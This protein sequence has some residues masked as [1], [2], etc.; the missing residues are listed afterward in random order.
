MVPPLMA[1]VP[2]LPSGPLVPAAPT[3]LMFSLPE[4]SVTPPVKVLA[5]SK[6]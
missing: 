5:P 6:V 3:E 1:K 2:P 4:V